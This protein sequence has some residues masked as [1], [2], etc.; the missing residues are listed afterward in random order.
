MLFTN[1]NAIDVNG[2]EKKF[3]GDSGEAAAIQGR[4]DD[5]RTENSEQIR[6]GTFTDPAM[7]IEEHHLIKTTIVSFFVPGEIGGPGGDLGAAE[8]V[9][10][11]PRIGFQGEANGPAPLAQSGGEGNRFE[12]ASEARRFK[13]ATMVADN[14]DTKRGVSRAVCG[15]ERPESG[16]K[17]FRRFRQ[18]HAEALRI[19]NHTRPMALPSEQDPIGDTERTEDTPAVEKTNLTREKAR[20]GGFTNGIVVQKEAVHSL[21]STNVPEGSNMNRHAH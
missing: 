3:P 13:E 7:F 17:L 15:D 14:G 10:A 18:R 1:C 6:R 11:M 5:I 8:L 16:K 9:S 12:W 19:A 21:Y 2:I 20:F 4:S